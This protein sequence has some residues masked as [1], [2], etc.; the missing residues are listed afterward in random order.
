VEAE[1]DDQEF[2]FICQGTSGAS[3]G[4]LL[5]SMNQST[6]CA[7]ISNAWCVFDG[8]LCIVGD[9]E[10]CPTSRSTISKDVCRNPKARCESIGAESFYGRAKL[11]QYS[12]VLPTSWHLWRHYQKGLCHAYQNDLL[13]ELPVGSE[14]I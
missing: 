14:H 10:F 8:Q 3:Y 13:L 12:K 2:E 5:Q 1:S 9:E 11:C 6:S 4:E 7:T